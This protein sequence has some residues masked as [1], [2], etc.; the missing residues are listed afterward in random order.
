MDGGA[1]ERAIKVPTPMS[2]NEDSIGR[3]PQGLGLG[4]MKVDGKGNDGSQDS[5]HVENGPKVTNELA[6]LLFTRVGHHHGTLSS[7]EHTGAN[8]ENTTSGDGKGAVLGVV[9]AEEGTGV[10]DIGGTT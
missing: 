5:T 6:F 8:T 1:S 3:V 9:V 7:P 10:E 4:H 2:G